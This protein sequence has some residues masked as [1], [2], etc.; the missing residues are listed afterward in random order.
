MVKSDKDLSIRYHPALKNTLGHGQ[1][2][3]LACRV[4]IMQTTT[5]PE[6]GIYQHYKG[7]R[8]L[9]LGTAQHSETEEYLVI[10]RALYGEQGLWVRP[11]SMFNENVNVD[12]KPS[13]RF[14]LIEAKPAQI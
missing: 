7:Q 1:G 8:Y 10:Y 13:P 9:V 12:N 11:L 6:P 4:T 2:N 14:Q 5:P 3:K